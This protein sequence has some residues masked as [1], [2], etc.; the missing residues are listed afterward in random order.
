LVWVLCAKFLLTIVALGLGVPG[1]IIGPVFVIGM[2]SGV[3]LASPLGLFVTD[4]S[5]LHSSFSLLGM[6]GLMA[7]VVHAPLAALSAVME[8]SNSPELILPAILV[9][10]PAYVTSTQFLGNSSI[11]IRQLDYQKL[12]YAITSV[13]AFLQRTG[14][15]AIMDTEF[16]LA[17]QNKEDLVSEFNSDQKIVVYKYS[18]DKETEY[19]LVDYDDEQNGDAIR[20]TLIPMNAVRFQ[21]TLAEVYAILSIKRDG[22]VYIFSNTTEDIIGT[23]TWETLSHYLHQASY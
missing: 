2:L 23:I 7:A 4:T 5:E 10:V 17:K 21:A 16:T 15:L 18:V 20:I 8:L 13:M 12:P 11:F 19:S 14:V 6:A 9:I 3:L 22:A 1:G